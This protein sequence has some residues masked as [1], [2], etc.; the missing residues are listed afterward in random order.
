MGAGTGTLITSESR[1]LRDPLYDGNPIRERASV[2]TRIA[3]S[4]LRVGSFEIAKP[5]DPRT[6]RGGPSYALSDKGRGVLT[7]RQR[8]CSPEVHV[9]V[10]VFVCMYVCVRVFACACLLM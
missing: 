2:I 4:F 10:Y 6:D 7:V 5:P 8:G 9:C 3:R 1:I